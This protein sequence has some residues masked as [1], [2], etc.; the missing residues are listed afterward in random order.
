MVLHDTREFLNTYLAYDFQQDTVVIQSNVY[1]GAAAHHLGLSC[2][3]LLLNNSSNTVNSYRQISK[4]RG[5]QLFE[6]FEQVWA[7][8]QHFSEPKKWIC[9]DMYC[10]QAPYFVMAEENTSQVLSTWRER[11]RVTATDSN[12]RSFMLLSLSLAIFSCIRRKTSYESPF[13]LRDATASKK[14]FKRC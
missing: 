9:V 2:S 7:Q 6:P 1:R 12:S 8:L 10:V 3:P 5:H 11:E 13:A 14:V 4:L